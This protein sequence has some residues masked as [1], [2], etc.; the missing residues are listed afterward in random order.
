MVAEPQN[1]LGFEGDRVSLILWLVSVGFLLG[2]LF[3]LEDGD[4]MFHRNIIRL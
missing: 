2:L 1:I 4:D 3:N